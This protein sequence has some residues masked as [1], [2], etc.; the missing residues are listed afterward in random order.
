MLTVLYTANIRDAK[1]QKD[2]ALEEY[3]QEEKK[4]RVQEDAIRQVNQKIADK[5]MAVSYS[6]KCPSY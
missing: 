3:V 1:A 2:A 4:A 5:A 6:I